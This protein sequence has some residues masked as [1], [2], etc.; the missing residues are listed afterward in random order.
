MPL[1]AEKME[2]E[3]DIL[4]QMEFIAEYY[5]DLQAIVKVLPTRFLFVHETVGMKVEALARIQNVAH[6]EIS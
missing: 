5:L 1:Q 6:R 2:K 4:A 3:K